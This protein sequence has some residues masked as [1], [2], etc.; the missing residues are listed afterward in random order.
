MPFDPYQPEPPTDLFILQQALDH[1]RQ[2]NSWIKGSLGEP[3]RTGHCAVGWLYEVTHENH[4]LS[5]R[6]IRDH[7]VPVMP[8][9]VRWKVRNKL[10]E[11]KIFYYNDRYGYRKVVKLF[12]RAVVRA[13]ARQTV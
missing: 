9:R 2:P 13:E 1:L 12:E 3:G 6:I 8:L 11:H 10:S 5:S 4:Q 7:L